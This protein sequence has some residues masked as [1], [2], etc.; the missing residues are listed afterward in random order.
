[1]KQDINLQHHKLMESITC[2]DQGNEI[3]IVRDRPG[4]QEEKAKPETEFQEGKM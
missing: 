2:Y 3:R 4:F 1:M